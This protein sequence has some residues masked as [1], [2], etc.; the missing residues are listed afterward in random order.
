M[1]GLLDLYLHRF[2]TLETDR[3]P[4]RWT[5][6]TRFRPPG[7]PLLLL[8]VL[9]EFAATVQHRNCIEPSAALARTYAGYLSLLPGL[10]PDGSL[11]V[12]FVRLAAAGCWHLVGRAGVEPRPERRVDSLEQL[13]LLYHGARFD[14]DL[15]PLL[16]MDGSREKLR[17]GLIAAS[18]APDLGAVIA[19]QGPGRRNLAG[20]A[21]ALQGERRKNLR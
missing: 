11:A 6:A 15:Y 8:S 13:R 1:C 21:P 5:A 9:D 17:T 7:Q 2:A 4:S 16:L 20:T 19:R 14:P 18:F 3:D 12:P 10:A